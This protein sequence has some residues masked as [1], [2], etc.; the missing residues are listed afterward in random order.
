VTTTQGVFRQL[1]VV[2]TVDQ[3]GKCAAL[4][5][6]GG[7][8]LESIIGHLDDC[9]FPAEALPP[10]TETDTVAD[11]GAAAA[12]AIEASAGCH[13]G[14]S[15]GGGGGS[16]SGSGVF[17]W[18]QFALSG[19]L[20]SSCC[21]LQLL[22]NG[23]ASFDVLHVGCAGFNKVSR[24]LLEELLERRAGVDGPA[25]APARAAVRSARAPAA[26]LPRPLL[27]PP[28]PARSARTCCPSDSH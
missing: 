10:D 24:G 18:A 19:L 3:G 16:G 21:A 7:N 8:S 27:R 1:N 5:H 12:A 6:L 23:L 17:G 4:V 26:L 14:T 11:A 20:S 25:Q 15:G 28:L 22:L 13:E 2:A 9:G